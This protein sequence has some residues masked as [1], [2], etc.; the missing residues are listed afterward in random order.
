MVENAEMRIFGQISDLHQARMLREERDGLKKPNQ[1][2]EREQEQR[3]KEKAWIGEPIQI[4]SAAPLFVGWSYDGCG[5]FEEER[6]C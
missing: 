4:V 5:E 1:I 2:D 3:R 6:L